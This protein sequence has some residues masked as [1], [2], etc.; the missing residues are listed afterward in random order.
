[1]TRGGNMMM[2]PYGHYDKNN[3]NNNANNNG[4][5]NGNGGN[6]GNNG[7]AGSGAKP[8]LRFSMNKGILGFCA[9]SGK[10]VNVLDARKDWR[11]DPEVDSI[12]DFQT[13]SLLVV[14][15]TD[16]MS[17]VSTL[18]HTF[19]SRVSHVSEFSL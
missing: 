4:G 16:H 2:A 15:V 9:T 10:P 11:F 17:K 1:M 3:Y 18:A 5:L 14:P 13:R 6:G 8:P 12:P 7:G 19:V